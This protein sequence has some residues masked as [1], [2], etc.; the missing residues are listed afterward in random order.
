MRLPVLATLL[1]AASSAAF[2]AAAA[3]APAPATLPLA[4]PV[5]A[6]RGEPNVRRTVIDDGRARIE[7]L[8]VRGQLKRVTVSPKGA[9]PAY[10]IVVPDGARDLSE[11]VSSSRG[12]AGQRVWNVFRF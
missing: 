12:A 6:E 8:R 5:T 11:G 7:E 4:E 9:A 2:S 3:D 1:A 10:E